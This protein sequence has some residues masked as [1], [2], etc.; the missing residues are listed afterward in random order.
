MKMNAKDIY[1]K[2]VMK[3]ITT[4][5][6][7]KTLIEKELRSEIDS[8]LE[9]GETWEEIEKRMGTPSEVSHEFMENLPE[10][11]S[12]KPVI[13]LSILA[14][15]I[16][17]AAVV[18]CICL[19]KNKSEDKSKATPTSS[20]QFAGYDMN[21]IEE[22]TK[23]II[24]LINDEDYEQLLNKYCADV[25]KSNDSMSDSLASAKKSIVDSGGDYK[26]KFKKLSTTEMTDPTDYLV[27]IVEAEYEHKNVIYTLSFDKK[28]ML[29]GLYMR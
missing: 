29:I 12:K 13:I 20:S 3:K 8:A 22:R 10:S 24:L 19:P 1:L 5:R 23:Q 14:G 15:C 16:V 17:I 27:Y 7:K 2:N 26:N 21:E 4:T 9:N 11:K 25:L 18:L 6:K 28:N